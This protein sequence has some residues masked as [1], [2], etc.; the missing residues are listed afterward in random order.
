MTQT[1]ASFHAKMESVAHDSALAAAM[2]SKFG[3]LEYED[4]VLTLEQMAFIDTDGAD[5]SRTVYK[6]HAHDDAGNRYLVQWPIK[7]SILAL[8]QDDRPE[9]ESEW[10]D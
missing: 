9:D 8:P 7:D 4:K 5:T 3:G 6:A 1:A 10:C 2:A